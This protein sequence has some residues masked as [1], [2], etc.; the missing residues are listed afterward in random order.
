MG[1]DVC[2]T[3]NQQQVYIKR[4]LQIKNND[5]SIEKWARLSQKQIFKRSIYILKHIQPH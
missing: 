5:N 2:N 4:T 3:H 1:N